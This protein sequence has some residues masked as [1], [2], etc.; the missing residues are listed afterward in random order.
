MPDR[1]RLEFAEGVTQLVMDYAPVNQFNADFLGE[2]RA[3]V[4][5]IDPGTR[6]VVVMSAVPGIF[7]AGGD[8]PWLASAPIDEQVVFVG[9]CQETYGAFERLAV[10]VV[11]AVDGHCL[12]GGLELALCCDIRVVGESARLGLPEATIGLIAAAGGTQRLVRAVGQGVA[13]DMLLTGLRISGAQAGQWGLAS[14]V[15]PDGEAAREALM[16]A[17]QLADGPA[18][19]IQGTKR[20]AVRAS[21]V[22]L[23]DGLASERAEWEAARRSPSTQEGL[24]AFAERRTPDFDG[25]RGRAVSERGS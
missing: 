1:V 24:E 7:A 8:L 13:R 23:E 5:D 2:I 3:A 9:Q 21:E 15:A 25:A 18:E 4:L 17:R 22:A 12:G 19:A 6:A 11:V 14:R 16:I 10:P 20:L